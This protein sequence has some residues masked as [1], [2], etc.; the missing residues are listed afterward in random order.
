[1]KDKEMDR[2][3]VLRILKRHRGSFTKVAV[4]AKVDISVVSH[5]LQGT[6]TSAPVMDV[7]RQMAAGLLEMEAKA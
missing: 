7:A 4:Q 2:K 3:A 6:H 5:V 1:M